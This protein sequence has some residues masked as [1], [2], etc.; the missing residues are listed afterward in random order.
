MLAHTVAGF[1]N[2]ELEPQD[3]KHRDWK[4]FLADLKELI[5]ISERDYDPESKLW[6]IKATEENQRHI[7]ALKELY[8]KA[9]P[10]QES[11]FT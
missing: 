11:L 1:I 8:F 10:N 7:K 4:G 2:L 6:H 9:D 5:P 3:F